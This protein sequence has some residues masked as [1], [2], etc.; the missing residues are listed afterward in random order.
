MESQVRSSPIQSIKI[1]DFQSSV[2][3][4]CFRFKASTQLYITDDE[5]CMYKLYIVNYHWKLDDYACGIL[6]INFFNFFFLTCIGLVASNKLA[7]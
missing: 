2:K 5:Q 6:N 1:S 4:L 7:M 3:L